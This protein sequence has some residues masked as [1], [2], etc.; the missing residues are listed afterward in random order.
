MKLTGLLS[1]GAAAVLS[2]LTTA[3]AQT[4]PP[5]PSA[6][7]KVIF[8]FSKEVAIENIAVRANGNLLLSSLFPNASLY[9]LTL[10]P[11]PTVKRLTTIPGAS[12]VFGIAEI[13]PDVFV[14]ATGI[15]DEARGG[16]VE[17]ASS[18]FRATF[19]NRPA[20]QPLIEKITDFPTDGYLN[21]VTAVPRAGGGTKLILLADSVRGT[22][23]VLDPKTKAKGVVLKDAATMS[24]PAGAPF[25]I[26]ING[27]Q[28]D[29]ATSTLYYSNTFASLLAKVKI[30]IL[31][32]LSAGKPPIIRPASAFTVVARNVVSDDFALAPPG[33]G[34]ANRALLTAN[35]GNVVWDVNLDTGRV[36][37]LLGRPNAAD[38]AG[39]TAAQFGRVNGAETNELFVTTAG[40]QLA[41]VNGT[42]TEGGKIVS[43]KV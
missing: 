41:P 13:D 8:Q 40:G 14:F 43:V 23:V 17:G 27:V 12:S 5:P 29:T 32:A 34:R 21:G 30:V 10:H 9:E 7:G 37:V 11:K 16:P 20:G 42:F 35:T 1:L 4:N 3:S 22:V 15:F 26:G 33:N 19:K 31:P 24:P 18:A 39:A 36:G 38:V 28:F 2:F 25:P 6:T